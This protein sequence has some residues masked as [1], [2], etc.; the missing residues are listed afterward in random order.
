MSLAIHKNSWHYRLHTTIRSAWGWE[1]SPNNQWSLC[2]YFHTTFWGS[3][4]TVLVMPLV[5]LGWICLKSLRTAYKLGSKTKALGFVPWIIDKTFLGKELDLAARRYESSP[6]LTSIV[7]LAY[8]VFC[9]LSIALSIGLVAFVAFGGLK[10]IPHIPEYLAIA[11]TYIGY[12]WFE[13]M[14]GIGWFLIEIG[15]DLVAAAVAIWGWIASA[16]QWI[17]GTAT[18][19]GFWLKAGKVV[20]ATLIMTV[21]SCGSVLLFMMA[22]TCR[23]MKAFYN[24][25][26]IK[27]NGYMEARAKREWLRTMVPL[28]VISKEELAER[29][30]KHRIDRDNYDYLSAGLPR[31]KAP[32]EPNPFIEKW[33]DMLEAAGLGIK[34]LILFFIGL[35]FVAIDTVSALYSREGTKVV[36]VDGEEFTQ[37]VD[38]L[39]P[40]GI[41][42]KFLVGLKKGACPILEFVDEGDLE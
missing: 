41:L 21:F 5:I 17:F 20:G 42:W 35:L 38:I 15:R 39:G 19:G 3:L 12:V 40:L 23:P 8:T 22:L 4:L 33:M 34:T 28:K 11:L 24:W 14:G 13:A 29:I 26:D 25:C 36:V 2:A 30:R 7:W 31:E 32:K 1:P 6:I 16:A 18:S 27:A 9:I 37:K 10:L